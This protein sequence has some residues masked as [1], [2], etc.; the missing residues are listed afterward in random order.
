MECKLIESTEK[1]TRYRITIKRNIILL[2]LLPALLI[3]GCQNPLDDHGPDAGAVFL[4]AAG[5]RSGSDFSLVGNYGNYWSSSANGIINYGYS[6]YCLS[7][8]SGGV[9][10]PGYGQRYQGLPVRLVH[11]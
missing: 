8:S 1:K 2:F 3:A 9:Y 4:P 10:P 6:A 5:V 11:D 7:F